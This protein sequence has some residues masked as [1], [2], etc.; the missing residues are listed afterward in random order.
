MEAQKCFKAVAAGIAAI[1]ISLGGATH[2]EAA[3]GDLDVSFDEDGRVTTDFFGGTDGANAVVLQ[4]NGK[5]V[6]AG[7]A[8]D[9]LDSNR[10][11]ALARYNRDGSLDHTFGDGGKVTTD[12]S[13]NSGTLFSETA[14]AV[15]LQRDGRIVVAGGAFNPDT[16]LGSFAVL[17]YT[18]HGDLD[19]TFGGAG[20]VLTSFDANARA[21]DLAVQSDGKLVVAG[22]IDRRDGFTEQDFVLARYNADGSLDQDFGAGGIVVT[23]LTTRDEANALRLTPDGKILVAGQ[24]FCLGFP[25]TVR[26]FVLMRYNSDGSLDPTFGNGG[27]VTTHFNFWDSATS[28]DVAP[29]GKIILAG[30]AGPDCAG[31]PCLGFAVARYNPDGSID[32]SFGVD[33]KVQTPLGR[34]AQATAVIIPTDLENPKILVG[35]FYQ[36]SLVCGTPSETLACDFALIRYNWDGSLDT[37]FGNEGIVTTDFGGSPD[38][39]FDLAVQKNGRIILAGT[40]G[41]DFALARY[42]SDECL[43]PLSPPYSRTLPHGLDDEVNDLACKY[44]GGYWKD[45]KASITPKIKEVRHS[46]DNLINGL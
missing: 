11:F 24:T 13:G 38:R 28:L 23:N 20:F 43:A 44:S 22:T 6:A 19:P 35:G 3:P 9:S 8:F 46:V 32:A 2:V 21:N 36:E 15:R 14:N 39:A 17:R 29:D 42:L 40:N 26:D 25:C 37:S 41:L 5:I 33:G 7:S 16:S 45:K 12:L 4:R 10:D 31:S 18:Q 27:V 34:F 1:I 30:Y